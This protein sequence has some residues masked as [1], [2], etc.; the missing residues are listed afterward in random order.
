[1][2]LEEEGKLLGRVSCSVDDV[3]GSSGDLQTTWLEDFDPKKEEAFFASSPTGWRVATDSVVN[4]YLAPRTSLESTTT[5]A[6]FPNMHIIGVTVS[7]ILHLDCALHTEFRASLPHCQL[8][9]SIYIRTQV[10][11]DS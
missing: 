2:V 8:I 7:P 3:K 11:S 10:P 4:V 5:W 6:L 9:S 1:V